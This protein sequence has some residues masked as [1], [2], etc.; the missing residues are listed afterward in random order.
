MGISEVSDSV[1]IIVSE[2]TGR[3]SVARHGKLQAGVTKEELKK[4]L[5]D[6]QNKTKQDKPKHKIWKG[7]VKNEE[8]SN[9]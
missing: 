1:T 3:V 7:L 8:K 4:I 9:E 5:E 2:E 6:E